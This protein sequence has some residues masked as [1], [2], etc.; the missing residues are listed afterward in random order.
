MPFMIGKAIVWGILGALTLFIVI[1]AVVI[2]LGFI[3]GFLA[4]LCFIGLILGLI[5]LVIIGVI[6]VFSIP[7][8]FFGKMI[9]EE[10]KK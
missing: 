1:A 10:V 3:G 9:E 5:L 4:T 7:F 6:V 8:W 2:L